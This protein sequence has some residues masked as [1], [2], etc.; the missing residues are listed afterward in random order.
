MDTPQEIL[1][2]GWAIQ[3]QKIEKISIGHINQTYSIRASKGRFALQCVNPI[4]AESV[5]S[6]IAQISAHLKAE[7]LVTPMLIPTHD[8]LYSY[9]SKNDKIW[10]LLSWIEGKCVTAFESPQQAQSAAALL[11]KLH[12]ALARYRKPLAHQRL[13]V[14]DT[15]AHINGLKNALHAAQKENLSQVITLATA[16]I[17]RLAEIPQDFGSERL[18]HGDPKAS[19]IIFDPNGQALAFI[20]LDTFAYMPTLLEL[21]DAFRSWCAP[22]GEDIIQPFNTQLYARALSAYLA[23]VGDSWIKVDKL[24]DA[25]E[26]IALELAARFCRDAI[27]ENYFNWDKSRF[28]RA[29]EHN[30]L[31]AEAQYRLALSLQQRKI[32]IKAATPF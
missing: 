32:E 1:A 27:E 8:G 24:P 4:F 18:V 25:I 2:N 5:N 10:R 14:H 6:D 16:I 26:V 23:E 22:K 31:R 21:G 13:N 9:R 15:Q 12:F 17:D 11:G 3:P 19:N 29:R 30:Y 28:N 20:D 7:G